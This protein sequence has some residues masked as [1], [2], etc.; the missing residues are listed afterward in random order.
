MIVKNEEEVLAR[1]LR[2]CEGLFD[3]IVIADTGSTDLTEKIAREFTDKIY[4]FDWCDDFSKARNFALSKATGDY[5]V[6]LDADDVITPENREKFLSLFKRIDVER[7][8]VVMLPYNVGFDGDR[9]TLSYFRERIFRTGAGLLFEGKVHEAVPPRGKIIY[10]DA[11]VEHRK[12]R[13][14]DPQRNLKIYEKMAAAGEK[15]SP[16]DRYYYARELRQAGRSDEAAEQFRLCGEDPEAWLENRIS[17]LFELS[18]LLWESGKAA[19]SLKALYQCLSLKEPRADICCELGRRFLESGDLRS[20]KFW[21]VLAPEQFKKPLGGFVHADFG[22]IIPYLQLC[23]ICDRLGERPA[24]EKYNALAAEI[25][26]NHPSVIH[27]RKY[28]AEK[29]K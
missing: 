27:N 19:D 10:A 3:E 24:A 11:A 14:G 17:A 7:P 12:L 18:G 21:Y 4:R 15:F 16:R 8:D 2:S 23:V 6:W 20:A 22:G 13:P 28:F 25:S 5:A 26:P 9:V 29:T 1:C